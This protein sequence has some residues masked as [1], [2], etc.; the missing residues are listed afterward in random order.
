MTYDATFTTLTED[1]FTESAMPLVNAYREAMG[2]RDTEGRTKRADIDAARD[3][4]YAHCNAW[5]VTK[6]RKAFVT[7]FIVRECYE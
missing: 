5:A 7:D 3:A 1:E 4:L 2:K 6:A